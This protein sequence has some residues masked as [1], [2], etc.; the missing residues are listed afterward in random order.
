MEKIWREYR[1]KLVEVRRKARWSQKESWMKS[2]GTFEEVRKDEQVVCTGHK[3]SR[4]AKINIFAFL[5]L[6]C[7]GNTFDNEKLTNK[8]FKLGPLSRPP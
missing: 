8:L 6:I 5:R 2:E 4:L 7:I 3:F 1:W